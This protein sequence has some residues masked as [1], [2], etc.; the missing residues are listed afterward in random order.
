V[1]III[2]ADDMG[3]NRIINDAIFSCFDKK[4]ITSSTI[5]A[6]GT[7]LEYAVKKIS[8]Y[9]EFSF[10]VHLNLSQF[11]SL[12]KPSVFL[13]EQIVDENWNFLSENLHRKYKSSYI[14]EAIFNEWCMQ[15]EKILDYGIKISHFDSHHSI[16]TFNE[17]LP[18]L[19]KLASKYN[20]FKIRGKV[21]LFP[22]NTPFI[23]YLYKKNK[24]ALWRRKV[25]LGNLIT[26]SYFVELIQFYE[27]FLSYKFNQNDSIEIMVH[28]GHTTPVFAEENKILEV[29]QWKNQLV[30]KAKFIGFNDF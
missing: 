30:N 12:T 21:N 18:V 27:N 7:D 20:I 5:M 1:K 11:T 6:N 10:G 9:S 8:E 3:Y 13:E 28:P 25:K 15:I 26:T 22:N 17:I 19:Y 4:L 23:K 2:N 24:G 29:G 16:H 14:I